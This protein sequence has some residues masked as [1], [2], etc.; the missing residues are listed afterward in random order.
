MFD[1]GYHKSTYSIYL[2]VPHNS[3]FFFFAMSQFDWPIAKKKLK[4]YRLPKILDSM[5]RWSA[6]PFG[7]AICEK[8]EDFGQNIWD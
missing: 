4:L 2:G 8:G 3:N 7:P 5:E 6:S 1:G